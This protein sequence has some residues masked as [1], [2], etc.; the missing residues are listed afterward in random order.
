VVDAIV[1]A[2]GAGGQRLAKRLDLAVQR[3]AAGRLECR[4]EQFLAIRCGDEALKKGAPDSGLTPR[5]PDDRR[6]HVASASR[7]HSMAATSTAS[8]KRRAAPRAH[9][10]ESGRPFR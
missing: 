2:Q 9:S 1:V 3:G 4:G 8:A 5:Q 6:R 10:D 7:A